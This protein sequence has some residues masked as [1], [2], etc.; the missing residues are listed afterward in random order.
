MADIL[1]PADAPNA[2]TNRPLET[3][4][5]GTLDSYF[6]D[7]SSPTVEDGTDIQAGFFNGMVAALRSVWRANGKLADGVTNVVAEVGTD[8]DGLTKSLQHLI[9][10]GQPIYAVGGGTANVITASLSPALLEYKA[11]LTVRIKIISTNSGPATLNINGLGAKVCLRRDGTPVL[12]GDIVAGAIVTFIYNGTQFLVP[13]AYGTV[14]LPFDTTI[15]VR[16]TG[17]DA[18]DGSADTDAKALKTINAAVRR[19][20]F[21]N[22]GQYTV[23]IKVADGVF[24]EAVTCPPLNGSG[25]LLILGNT[26]TPS[27]CYLH[28]AAG[29]GFNVTGKNYRIRGFKIAVDSA[30]GGI[31]AGIRVTSGQV[32]CG[33]IEFGACAGPHMISDAGSLITFFNTDSVTVTGNATQHMLSNAAGTIDLT[34]LTLGIPSAV[35]FSDAFAK[36]Q[37]GGIIQGAY[38]IKS[39][40]GAVTGYRY[41][42][43]TNGVIEGNGSA[44]YYPGSIAGV[45]GSGGQY[46]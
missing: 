22:P 4:T 5:F 38:G 21:Y 41:L 37:K 32:I 25:A 30:V 3:R 31:G 8:D 18:N 1:G 34:G 40:S 24:A 12:V 29:D 15:F 43:S 28:P 27:N 26:V 2:V 16:A 39:I 11:G 6:K 13:E 35:A 23:T 20:L 14:N 17:N 33:N 7:C 10:R 19:A 45:T 44:T 9:Q 46:T 36:A 42:A